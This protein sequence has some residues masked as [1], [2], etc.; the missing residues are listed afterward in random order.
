MRLLRITALVVLVAATGCAAGSGHESSPSNTPTSGQPT[1]SNGTSDAAVSATDRENGHT[2]ALL[3]GQRLRVELSNT[4]WQFQ[5]S[6]DRSVL[7]LDGVPQLSPQTSGCAAYV[8]CGTA[9]ATY[10]GVAA[11]RAIVT[12]T[13]TSCGEAMGCTGSNARYSLNVVVR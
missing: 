13:R 9:T 10:I 5:D 2:I 8:G 11:G 4:H 3:R 1:A 7:R 12:A 6:S